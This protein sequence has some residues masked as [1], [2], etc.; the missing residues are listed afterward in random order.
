MDSFLSS[1]RPTAMGQ[2][3]GCQEFDTFLQSVLFIF[4]IWVQGYNVFTFKY[5]LTRG[6]LGLIFGL[7]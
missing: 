4:T 2:A 3:L 5:L 7:L 6:A 1:Y